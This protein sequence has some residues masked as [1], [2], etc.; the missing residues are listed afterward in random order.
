[1]NDAA[2][3]PESFFE[4]LCRNN[5]NVLFLRTKGDLRVTWPRPLPW[6]EVLPHAL[7]YSQDGWNTYFTVGELVEGATSRKE[8]DMLQ[9]RALLD[10]LDDPVTA[11]HVIARREAGPCPPSAVVE[12]SPGKFQAFYF[13]EPG[14]SWDLWRHYQKCLIAD[15]NEAMAPLLVNGGGAPRLNAKG[16]PI[17][18]AD[19]SVID[20]PRIMRIPGSTHNK[21]TP[22]EGRIVSFTGRCYSLAEIAAWLPPYVPRPPRTDFVY[23]ADVFPQKFVEL[24]NSLDVLDAGRDEHGDYWEVVCPNADEHSDGRPEA[25]LYAPSDENH[26][27][28]G[29]NCFHAHCKARLGDGQGEKQIGALYRWVETGRFEKVEREVLPPAS[30]EDFDEIAPASVGDFDEIAPAEIV[31]DLSGCEEWVPALDTSDCVPEGSL[32]PFRGPMASIWATGMAA[33]KRKQPKL[34]VL[35]AL[36]GMAAC[37]DTRYHLPGG[38]RPH[39][40]GLG[41]AESSAGKQI[42]EN[43]AK[44]L[45]DAFQPGMQ[46]GRLASYEGLEDA[47]TRVADGAPLR[48]ADAPLR[49]PRLTTSGEVAYLLAGA[50]DMR[51]QNKA[52]LVGGLLEYFTKST[53][54]LVP[55]NVTTARTPGEVVHN[56]CLNFL[57]FSTPEK[58]S[59][60]LT[61]ESIGSGL[62]GRMLFVKGEDK[63]DWVFGQVASLQFQP[64]VLQAVTVLKAARHGQADTEGDDPAWLIRF[65]EASAKHCEA[66]ERALERTAKDSS[67]PLERILAGRTMEILLRIAGV[68]AVWDCPLEPVINEEHLDWAWQAMQESK[69]TARS[70]FAEFAGESKEEQLSSKILRIL[71][72]VA[73]DCVLLRKGQDAKNFK[74]P[75]R[76]NAERAAYRKGGASKTWLRDLVKSK[77]KDF[78]DAI[79]NL[80]DLGRIKLVAMSEYTN[81]VGELVKLDKQATFY[82]LKTKG[83]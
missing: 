71:E 64:E 49:L 5:P 9:P 54:R 57:G 21:G 60:V 56:P 59:P 36:V 28:G 6:R 47:F 14:L 22:F 62:A 37:L 18:A 39:L 16:S 44:A 58:L 38:M 76:D 41:I 61:E 7:K 74:L 13:I 23:T 45:A 40:Y 43:L 32:P 66:L 79:N 73:E 10:D 52:A 48:G 51:N 1:M 77:L 50:D 20:P 11:P 53:M 34:M 33:N 29:F 72:R 69:A 15:A 81:D 27:Q 65:T 17:M 8:A 30:V 4:V 63:P 35:G 70:F 3:T 68:L 26:G 12:T 24:L 78:E 42:P 25:R 75:R 46:M 19:R 2:S 82:Q 67:T 55:R 31:A 83:D 80:L